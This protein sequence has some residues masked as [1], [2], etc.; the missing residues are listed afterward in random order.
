RSFENG[1][2]IVSNKVEWLEEILNRSIELSVSQ[3][4]NLF[5][6]EEILGD[7][8]ILEYLIFIIPKSILSESDLIQNIISI[9]NSLA[10]IKRGS[11]KTNR[12]DKK[13][14]DLL[15]TLENEQIISSVEIK[16]DKS[17]FY[18]KHK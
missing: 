3:I 14:F 4:N 6:H 17:V 8:S 12:V 16:D 11:R 10:T 5:S 2:L 1:K 9:D 15:R 18:N 7:D 13:Y